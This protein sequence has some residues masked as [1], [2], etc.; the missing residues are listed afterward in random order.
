MNKE[1]TV[2]VMCIMVV[3]VSF[4]VPSTEGITGPWTP[5]GKKRNIINE[6]S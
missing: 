2:F 3:L 5:V 1:V 4:M 6:V